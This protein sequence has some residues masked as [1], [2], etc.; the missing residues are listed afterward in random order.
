MVL[1]LALPLMSVSQVLGGAFRGTLDIR[2]GIVAQMLIQPW[3]RILVII[4]LFMLGWRL[5]AVLW[6]TVFSFAVS[7][8][9]LVYQAQRSLFPGNVLRPSPQGL[10]NNILEVTRYSI[11]LSLSLSVAQLLS[12]TDILMLAYFVPSAETG[13]YAVVQMV[14]G[15]I[16]LFNTAFS[17]LLG[18]EIAGAYAQGDLREVMTLA[19]RHVRWVTIT[20]LP[21]FLALAVF[22]DGLIALFGQKFSSPCPNLPRVILLLASSNLVGAVFSST[23]FMLSMTGRHTREFAALLITLVCNVTINYFLIPLYG[24]V[25]AALST[26]LSTCIGNFLRLS[27]IRVSF[28][29]LPIGKDIFLPVAVGLLS[30]GPFAILKHAVSP[31]PRFF[32]A[33]LLSVFFILTYAV[34]ISKYCLSGVERALVVRLADHL[35]THLPKRN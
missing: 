7:T 28:R 24:I 9:F 22:G 31:H 8:S 18:P 12:R 23:G 21:V 13:R 6:G 2:P 25:G 35:R 14:T 11:V 30:I 17:Q 5:K 15:V 19:R 26:F 1:I 10:F 3:T 32:T 33:F 20:S 16:P 4:A 34:P 29:L 27:L